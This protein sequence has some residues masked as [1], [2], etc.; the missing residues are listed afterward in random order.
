MHERHQLDNHNGFFINWSFRI[1]D[2]DCKQLVRHNYIIVRHWKESL[3]GLPVVSR[4][5]I[6]F[7]LVNFKYN[8]NIFYL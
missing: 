7:A 5:S 8:P 1:I 4:H 6:F 2:F 3:D